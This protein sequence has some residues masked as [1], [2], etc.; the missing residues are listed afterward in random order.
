MTTKP[1]VAVRLPGSG[2][3]TPRHTVD[4]RKAA[5]PGGSVLGPIFP[6]QTRQRTRS[7]RVSDGPAPLSCIKIPPSTPGRDTRPRPAPP[8]SYAHIEADKENAQTSVS[9]AEAFESAEEDEGREEQRS[10]EQQSKEQ[11]Y[12]RGAT[13]EEVSVAMALEEGHLAQV[14]SGRSKGT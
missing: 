4:S 13:G 1:I 10:D 7:D 9:I 8:P 2:P 14:G 11:V 12:I 3:S 6:S 5:S